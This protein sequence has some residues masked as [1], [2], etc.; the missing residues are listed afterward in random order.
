[1]G[2]RDILLRH[3]HV[4]AIMDEVY[5]NLVYDGKEHVRL[6]SLPDMWD[7][8]L[9]VS[10]CGK[11]FSITGWK[12][13]WVYGPAHLVKP[14]TQVNQWVQFCVSTPTQHAIASMMDKAFEPYEGHATY[15]DYVREKYQRKRNELAET[16]RMAKLHPVVPEGGFFIMAD[17]SAYGNDSFPEVMWTEP[18]PNG[19]PPSRDWVFAR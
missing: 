13:G 6:A 19:E 18:A 7:R 9:T 1:M 10:S 4:S 11:T 12:V 5:E 14:V 17:I 3:D 16:L 2:I 8:T 15:F